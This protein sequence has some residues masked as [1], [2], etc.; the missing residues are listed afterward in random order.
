MDFAK[1]L[2][3]PDGAANGAVSGT[4]Q[5]TELVFATCLCAPRSVDENFSGNEVELAVK[6]Y[7]AEY[8]CP[9]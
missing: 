5:K 2:V 7:Q 1:R 8:V 4:G 6:K 3:K 9:S